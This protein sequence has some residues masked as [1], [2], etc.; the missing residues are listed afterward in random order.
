MNYGAFGQRQ[1]DIAVAAA[2]LTVRIGGTPTQTE[3]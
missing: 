1:G 2:A 3:Q